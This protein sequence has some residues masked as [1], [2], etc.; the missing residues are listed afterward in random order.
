[1]TQNR[2]WRRQGRLLA[3]IFYVRY[4]V[5]SVLSLWQQLRLF[6]EPR[7]RFPAWSI[8]LVTLQQ[9]DSDARHVHRD[10]ANPRLPFFTFDIRHGTSLG[11]GLLHL[12]SSVIAAQLPKTRL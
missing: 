5:H 2:F 3:T 6:L 1:M 8:G 7:P 10:L 9:K 11:V 4:K 12:M